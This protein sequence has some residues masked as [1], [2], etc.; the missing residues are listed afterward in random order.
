MSFVGTRVNLC[1]YAL[2]LSSRPFPGDAIKEFTTSDP[3]NR[4]SEQ[5]Q[6]YEHCYKNKRKTKTW[7]RFYTTT[8]CLVE[9]IFVYNSINGSHII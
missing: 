4:D 5:P 3:G 9:N 2:S 7:K 8:P 1:E 6:Q